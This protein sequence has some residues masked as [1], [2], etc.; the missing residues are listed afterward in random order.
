MKNSKAVEK[1][2]S[3]LLLFPALVL[4]L[5]L[6]V[7]TTLQGIFYS[8]T[9]W[10]FTSAKFA[11]LQNYINIFTEPSISIATKNTIIFAAVTTFFKV[12]LGLLLAIFLNRNIRSA[13]F[14]RT[15]YFLPC[16]ISNVAIGL[17]FSGILHPDGML[18]KLLNLVGLGIF[19]QEWLTDP[20][21]VI[22]SLSF[23]E[24]WKWTG[25]TMMI[26]LS[27]LQTVSK[28]YYEAGE[29][30]GVNSIQRLWYITLP[31]IMPTFNNAL[32]VNLIGGLKV[33]DIVYAVTGGGPGSASEVLNSYV[34]KAY[35]NGRYGESSA[36]SFVVAIMVV[37][38]SM[39]SYLFLNKKEVEHS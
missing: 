23:I 14:M 12:I 31:L 7:F 21:L 26:F 38:I 25:F 3:Y 8:F 10:N 6:F 32:M 29:V 20:K 18:N 2:Y 30:D 15:V 1:Q 13:N 16:V 5:V 28:D 19:A 35:G 34:F 17:V 24:I 27:G 37:V 36:A 33:F 22:F 39:S 11:G 9:Y 4:Y